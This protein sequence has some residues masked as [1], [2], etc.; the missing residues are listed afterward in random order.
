[1][2]EVGVCG[3][4]KEICHFDYGTPPAGADRLVL[5]HESLGEVVEVGGGVRD[6]KPGDL[7]VTMVRRPC[8]HP[9]CV[10][11]RAGRQDFCYTGD[12]KERGIKELHGFMSEFVVDE[13]KYMLRVPPELRE[14]GVLT[15]PLTI[16][17]KAITEALQVQQRLPWGE[18]SDQ[19]DTYVHKAV[20]LGAGPVG[21]LGAMALCV[22]GFKTFVYSRDEKPN[23]SADLVEKIGAIYIS[24]KTHSIAQLAEEVGNIDL[25][26]EA[27]GASKF[28][29]DTLGVL[30]TNGV[31][32][33][34]GVPG[35]KAPV[36]LDTDLIM[37]N[38][39]LK[40]QV[41]FGSVNA[42]FSAYRSAIEDLA[43][44]ELRWPGAVCSLITGRHAMEDFST[45]VTGNPGGI[46]HVIQLQG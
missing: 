14:I 18:P 24:S 17:E 4:D 6:L 34:T 23:A 15:E 39:V 27:T 1:M 16:A 33:F 9:H 12:F 28:A 30:G 45:L 32:I 20:V 19:T 11:C 42:G 31:F 40:N 3:T 22:N 13:E 29:F 36:E 35:R 38:L 2:L 7:V 25:V 8:G 26:Y 41:V 21:L 5:G 46:K 44:F 43:K 10:A 37:R